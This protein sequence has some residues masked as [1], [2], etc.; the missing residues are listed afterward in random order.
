[1]SSILDWAQYRYVGL[2]SLWFVD[3]VIAHKLLGISSMTSV[4][5]D[6]LG[7]VRANFNRPL[8]C[9]DVIQGDLTAIIP[10]LELPNSRWLMWFDYEDGIAGAALND[11]AMIVG[12]CAPNTVI[13]VTMNAKLDQLPRKDANDAEIDQETSLRQIAGDLVPTPLAANR[14]TR[15]KYPKLLCEI[16]ANHFRSLTVDSGR[17]ERF[18]KLV[19]LVYTDGTPMIT[20]GGIVAGADE[21]QAIQGVLTAGTW[22]AILDMP[23]AIPP[24]TMKEK[25]ALD[26]LMPS[27]TPPTDAQMNDIGFKLKREQIDAYHRLYLH[28][29]MFAEFL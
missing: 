9:I 26:R 17:P 21:F 16:L 29:P 10:T 7:F 28:Y 14:L 27:P 19:D 25:L 22:D 1:L 24:L 23:I 5:R 18:L 6:P 12:R 2:G 8:S 11:I 15:A 4:E 20:V 13:L 3:F